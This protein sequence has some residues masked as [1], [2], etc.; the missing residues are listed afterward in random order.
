MP[1]SA[2]VTGAAPVW[3]GERLAGPHHDGA[4]VHR[5]AD[6]VYL[7]SRGDVI[8]IVSRHASP[9]PC[10]IATRADSVAQLLGGRAPAVGD[11][12]R[13]GGGSLEVGG[14]RVRVTRFVDF[15]MP[16]FDRAQAPRMLARLT[17]RTATA[18]DDELSPEVLALLRERPAAALTQVLGRG[19]GLT[20][21]G[22]D[23]VCG[24]LATL[25]A[26]HDP[27]AADLRHRSRALAPGRTTALS[28]TLLHRAGE[29]DVLPA[30]ARV[31]AALLHPHE[32][33]QQSGTHE[34]GARVAE[35]RAV[36]HT[37]GAG[38]L[39]GLRLALDHINTRSCP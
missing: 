22:D 33:A 12:V 18:P 32:P 11:P 2:V 38:M 25:L 15:A 5:G 39:L 4:V 37:S 9:V 13:I 24:L 27:C 31:V 20:P 7:E 35:L 6:A 17:S 8:G 21:Y 19:S 30:F 1:P 28:A 34:L 3:V 26:A 16:S 29:G 36:G 14:R 23:V 10:A